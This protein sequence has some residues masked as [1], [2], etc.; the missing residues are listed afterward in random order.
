MKIC[1]VDEA[2]DGDRPVPG[3]P[4][5]SPVLVIAGLVL[6]SADLPTVTHSFLAAKRRF[7]PELFSGPHFLDGILREVKGSDLRRS[8]RSGSRRQLRHAIGSLEQAVRLL[9]THRVGLVGRVWVKSLQAQ[10]SER[11]VYTF[12]IQDT[13][14]H[15][16]HHLAQVGDIG[17]LVCDSRTKTKNS[18]V[19]HSVFTRKFQI[20]GDAYPQ[21]VEMPVFGHSDNHA[22]LQLADLVVSALLF[23]MACRTYCRVHHTGP[24]VDPAYDHLRAR[25]AQRLGRMQLRYRDLTG[26]WKGGLTVSDQL[27]QRAGGDLLKPPAA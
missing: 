7:F 22:C 4:N 5:I 1:Y 18:S 21:L 9:E 23:P 13:A 10:P 25:F 2:G 12:S 14:R 24:H 6:D 26:R 15:L 17:L 19:A 20:T 11:S 16:Q 8:I 27:G 3:A